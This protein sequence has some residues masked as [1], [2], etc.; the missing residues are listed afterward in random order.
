MHEK[1]ASKAELRDLQLAGLIAACTII[2]FFAVYWFLQIQD[3]RE[4]LALA[5]PLGRIHSTNPTPVE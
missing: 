1:P 5:Y 3:V 4:L 2:T